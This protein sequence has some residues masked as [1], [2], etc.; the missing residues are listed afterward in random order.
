MRLK[1]GFLGMLSLVMLLSLAFLSS[2]QMEPDPILHTVTIQAP[3]QASLIVTSSS[4]GTQTVS[5]DNRRTF[6]II[7]GETLRLTVDYNS[8][9]N[10]YS[11]YQWNGATKTDE[12][13]ASAV[14][15]NDTSISV[16]FREQFSIT[17]TAPGDS[18][19]SM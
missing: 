15:S 4:I 19:L 18:D 2:C 12:L 14:I 1:S 3:S 9:E 5:S 8:T 17:F 11:V 10:N 13:N 6:S 7:A 16:V